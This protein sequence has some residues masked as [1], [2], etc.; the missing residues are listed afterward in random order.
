MA[1]PS[2]APWISPRHTGDSG[3]PPTK[4]PQMSVPPE[5]EASCMS[6]LMSAWTKSKLSALKGEPVESMALRVRRTCV[7]RGTSPLF[8]TASMY[9]AEVPKIVI[10]SASA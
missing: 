9:L 3:L 4:Q 1:T 10:A 7:S 6:A 8:F 2:I 5:I